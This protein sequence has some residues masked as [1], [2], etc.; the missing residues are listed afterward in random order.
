MNSHQEFE[1][2]F[3]Y[4]DEKLLDLKNAEI[5]FDLT[6][7]DYSDY[8][9]IKKEFAAMEE[10][11]QLYK[12]QKLARDVWAETLWVN[13]KPQQLIDGM[14]SYLKEFRK[15]PRVM[16]QMNVG[17]A[18]ED[19][20]K[21]FKNSVPLFVELKNEAMRERHWKELM[22]KT[23]KYFDMSPNRCDEKEK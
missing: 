15:M 12:L 1:D 3:I 9:A 16:R 18:L 19:S 8:G 4:M 21:N 22:Q 2:A 13:L 11:Y 14:E 17:R 5:L 20:M 23:G 6:P 10:L 7:A